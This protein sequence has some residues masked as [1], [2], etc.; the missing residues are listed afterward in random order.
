MPE[1]NDA[2]RRKSPR[3]RYRWPTGVTGMTRFGGSPAL[4]ADCNGKSLIFG[5]RCRDGKDVE[6]VPV[7]EFRIGVAENDV[8]VEPGA[9]FRIC[10]FSVTQAC[11]DLGL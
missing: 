3:A 7:D 11:E 10:H 8:I 6:A 2:R 5:R 9:W 4:C 1:T